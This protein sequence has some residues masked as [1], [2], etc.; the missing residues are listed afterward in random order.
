MGVLSPQV[1]GNLLHERK[2][3]QRVERENKG[4]S[5]ERREI[6]ALRKKKSHTDYIQNRVKLYGCI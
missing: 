2:Q 3:I 4:N 5:K 6:H 1:C